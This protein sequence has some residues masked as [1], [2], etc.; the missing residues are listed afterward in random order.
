MFSKGVTD[1]ARHQ[2]P[3]KAIGL[4]REKEPE[5]WD[6]IRFGALLENVTCLEGGWPSRIH[7]GLVFAQLFQ[8]FGPYL[9][10]FSDFF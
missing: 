3:R 1:L 6:A 2:R 5:I 10:V 9:R 7:F 8:F 4:T